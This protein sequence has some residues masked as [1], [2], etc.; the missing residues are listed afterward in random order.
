MLFL[1][2]QMEQNV[3]NFKVMLNDDE[4]IEQVEQCKYLGLLIDNNLTWKPHIL[5]IKKKLSI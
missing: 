5:H 1:P 2:S 4:E 3:E